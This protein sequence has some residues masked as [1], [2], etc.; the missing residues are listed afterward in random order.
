[1]FEQQKLHFRRLITETQAY[2]ILLYGR[3]AG[4]SIMSIDV[5]FLSCATVNQKII[6]G[7]LFR[8]SAYGFLCDF[9][10]NTADKL[11]KRVQFSNKEKKPNGSLPVGV[12]CWPVADLPALP[13]WPPENTSHVTS[14]KRLHHRSLFILKLQTLGNSNPRDQRDNISTHHE[15]L[16][17][18]FKFM[19]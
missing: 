7:I 8:K 11:F 10:K 15:P 6:N 4:Y 5:Y 9:L 2:F 12:G 16:G 1:M 17:F 13:V 14:E 19:I 3:S 18:G